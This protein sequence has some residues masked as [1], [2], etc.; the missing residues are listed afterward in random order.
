MKKIFLFS[1]VSCSLA[2]YA[3]KKDTNNITETL[4]Q[5]YDTT[6]SH[7][8]AI[9]PVA[10]AAGVKVGN[11]TSATGQ[12]PAPTG[13][14]AIVLDTEGYENL[15]YYAISNRYVAIFPHVSTG[16]VAGY[17]LQINGSG[18]HFKI[19]YPVVPPPPPPR[20]SSKSGINLRDYYS[21][22]A[23]IIKLPAGLKGDTFSIKYAAFD[24]D[25]NVSNSLSAYVKVISPKASDVAA[26]AGT[27]RLSAQGNGTEWH[28][29]DYTID[30]TMNW[31]TCDGKQLA[32]CQTGD[33][34]TSYPSEY[35]GQLAADFIFGTDNKFTL[36]SASLY[37]T[38]DVSAS[39]CGGK[40]SYIDNGS[41]YSE[42]A[43][44]AYNDSSKVITLIFDN[45]GVVNGGENSTAVSNLRV[46]SFKV[47]E[48]TST[49][50][51][52]DVSSTFGDGRKSSAAGRYGDPDI[53]PIYFLFNKQ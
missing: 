10:L 49:K 16:T 15:T 12:I 23:I 21:D 45:D 27:W 4:P 34:T 31:Y 40:L 17:Y 42:Y 14:S 36:Y 38:L 33:C 11:G 47:L 6:Y 35:F 28:P 5:T 29:S 22:S 48:L 2:F 39:T 37:K 32:E 46:S 25:N 1:A 30:S 9:D 53:Y 20:L 13:S 3:C 19:T 41:S 18:S 7:T 44:Y 50:L 24:K 52:L 43:G 51:K 26:I 8:P